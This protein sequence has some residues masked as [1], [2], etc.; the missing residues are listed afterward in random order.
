MNSIVKKILYIKYDL[1]NSFINEDH[2]VD[3][4]FFF[5]LECSYLHMIFFLFH[6]HFYL[7]YYT[8]C[9]GNDTS[10]QR[11]QDIKMLLSYEQKGNEHKAEINAGT[12]ETLC[13]H[14]QREDFFLLVQERIHYVRQQQFGVTMRLFATLNIRRWEEVEC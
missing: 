9:A 13:H 6:S 10:V 2:S 1:V 4:Y 14:F 3:P 12:D 5:V 11:S 8:G 7:W